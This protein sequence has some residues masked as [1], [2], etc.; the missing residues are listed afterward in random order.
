M[1]RLTLSAAL[2][3]AVLP[4]G[5]AQAQMISSREGIA[6]EN[7]ILELKQQIQQM[8]AGQGSGGSALGAPAPSPYANAPAAQGAAGA[9]SMLPNLL[10]Q[11]QSLQDE[12]QS[13]RG[14]VDTLEHE[15]STQHDELNQEI[16]DLKFQL[17]QQGQAAAQPAPQAR[18]GGPADAGRLGTLSRNA[19]PPAAPQA[20]TA[21]SR[22]A[23]KALAAHD[24]PTAEADARAI[25]AK[26]KTGPR[27]ADAQYIRAEALAAQ[28]KSQAAA[29]AYDDAYNADKA[30]PR[31]PDALLG[32]AASLTALHQDQAACDTLDSLASQFSKPSA[33]LARRIHL[34]RSRARCQ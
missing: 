3:G 7:Q 20:A 14:R 15:V 27:A 30:G 9:A 24:Y 1:R 19:A 17:S 29:L 8:Q 32:L 25:L 2:L 23:A 33:S 28:G 34:A 11:V 5:L 6:L 10:Q 31:A 18:P 4:F 16:G 22:A 21:S 13:L 12:V 26:T